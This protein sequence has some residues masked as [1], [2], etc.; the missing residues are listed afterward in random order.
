MISTEGSQVVLAQL[1]RGG[2]ISICG[3]V[4]ANR[5]WRQVRVCIF[6]VRLHVSVSPTSRRGGG[7]GKKKAL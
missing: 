2:E 3:R 7:G 6:Y 4:L 5:E 1:S